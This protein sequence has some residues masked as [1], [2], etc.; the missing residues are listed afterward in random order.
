M[1]I[2]SAAAAASAATTTVT[3]FVSISSVADLVGRTSE[4]TTP[5]HYVN[6]GLSLL[7]SLSGR[8]RKLFVLEKMHRFSEGLAECQHIQG[9]L[10]N[11]DYT[12]HTGSFVAHDLS[13]SGLGQE[14]LPGFVLPMPVASVLAQN[15]SAASTAIVIEPVDEV[16]KT[17]ADL[18]LEAEFDAIADTSG[19]NLSFHS[20]LSCA[21][22]PSDEVVKTQVWQRQLQ[23]KVEMFEFL[24]RKHGVK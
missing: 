23:K 3:S 22:T 7:D 17:E 16:Q 6:H 8:F 11:K 4:F 5:L 9:L 14:Y 18:L 1:I 19:N 13:G 12:S 10:K 24:I 15:D 21:C 20:M 2:P